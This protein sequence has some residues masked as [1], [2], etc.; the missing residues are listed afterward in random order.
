MN[1]FG[2]RR[3][4]QNAWSYQNGRPE[5]AIR[6]F[7]SGKS[8]A[9]SSSKSG[10]AY[11]MRAPLKTDEPVCTIIVRPSSCALA[12]SGYMRGSLT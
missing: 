7:S 12:Y 9:T 11:L 10:S 1:M 4:S 8:I 6:M 5:C 2:C 3:A